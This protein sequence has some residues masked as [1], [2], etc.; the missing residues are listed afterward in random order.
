MK[1]YPQSEEE[2]LKYDPDEEGTD[3]S[4]AVVLM[5][6]GFFLSLIF[7]GGVIYFFWWAWNLALKH[8]TI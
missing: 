5:W 3:M 4:C 7:Y 8:F 1:I 6:L 2:R